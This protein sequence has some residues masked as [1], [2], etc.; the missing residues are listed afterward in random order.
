MPVY[1]LDITPLVP[2]GVEIGRTC[3]LSGRGAHIPFEAAVEGFP[4]DVVGRPVDKIP[5]IM[6]HLAEHMRIARWDIVG[7]CRDPKHVSPEYPKGWWPQMDGPESR[8][9]WEDSLAAFARD[10]LARRA[11]ASHPTRAGTPG[12]VAAPAS[13]PC[14]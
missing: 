10:L 1:T 13:S 3:T 11:P 6:W 12:R 4:Y 7:F 14:S 9:A 2:Y 5:R 8:E